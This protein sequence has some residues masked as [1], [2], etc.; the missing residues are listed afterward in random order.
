MR[1][2]HLRVQERKLAEPLGDR[3]EL[4]HPVL[5][6]LPVGEKCHLRARLPLPGFPG[7]LHRRL[8]VSAFIFLEPEFPVLVHLHLKPL[9]QRVHDRYP[10]AVQSARHL[11][12]VL[13]ELSPRMEHRHDDLERGPFF[14][15]VKVC[16]YTAPVVQHGDGSVFV[17][18]H[19]DIAGK[20]RERFVDRVVDNLVHK[21][22]EAANAHV[23]DVHRGPPANG[24]EALEDGDVFGA[25]VVSLRLAEEPLCPSGE[26]LCSYRPGI[27]AHDLAVR[28]LT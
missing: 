25:V 12:G 20:S 9:A 3:V 28:A 4:E 21:V 10:D 14:S 5:E 15:L 22:V 17:D 6:N 16:R 26:M 23:A 19:V 24:L 2:L 18:R 27:M 1:E 8:R 11:V 13:V 7:D